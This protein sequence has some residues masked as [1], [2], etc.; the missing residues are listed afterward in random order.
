MGATFNCTWLEHYSPQAVGNVV[1]LVAA[2]PEISLDHSTYHRP[3]KVTVDDVGYDQVTNSTVL[4]FFL[5]TLFSPLS[6]FCTA[7]DD[8]TLRLIIHSYKRQQC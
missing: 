3:S 7:S 5:A 6:F 1:F 4:Q 2:K 8:M